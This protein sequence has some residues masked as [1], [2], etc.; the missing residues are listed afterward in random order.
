MKPRCLVTQQ[1]ITGATSAPGAEPA[2]A[3]KP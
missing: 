1:A 2:K 3:I